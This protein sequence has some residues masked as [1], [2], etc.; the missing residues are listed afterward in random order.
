ML[1]SQDPHAGPEGRHQQRP[2]RELQEQEAGRRH[3]QRDG[4]QQ[5]QR[6]AHQVRVWPLGITAS[7]PKEADR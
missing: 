2:L 6:T 1:F 7:G 4:Q 5:D 3:L